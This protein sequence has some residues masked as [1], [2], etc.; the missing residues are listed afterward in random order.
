M[1]LGRS[2]VVD[3]Y[4]R[5]LYVYVLYF[6]LKIYIYLKTHVNLCQMK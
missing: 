6:V 4:V 5:L 1:R 2:D 3:V